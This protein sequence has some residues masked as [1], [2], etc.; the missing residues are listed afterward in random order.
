MKGLVLDGTCE[1]K[2]N[3]PMGNSRTSH[4]V[5]VGMTRGTLNKII[6]KH[7]FRSSLGNLSRAYPRLE[8]STH[9]KNKAAIEWRTCTRFP[10]ARISVTTTTSQGDVGSGN[11]AESK[12]TGTGCPKNA[13]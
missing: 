7:V 9:C 13:N 11:V 3:V 5:R 6:L 4:E 8:P 10:I 12:L 1:I 2:P